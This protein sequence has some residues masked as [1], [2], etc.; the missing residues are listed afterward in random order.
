VKKPRKR[1]LYEALIAE[2]H[3]RQGDYQP[4]ISVATVTAEKKRWK[5]GYQRAHNIENQS[6]YL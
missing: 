6:T 5:D 3:R 1:A 4:L 2:Q